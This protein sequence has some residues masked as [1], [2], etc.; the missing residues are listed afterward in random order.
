MKY[1]MVNFDYIKLKRF[2]S[3]KPNAT[4]IRREA[5]KWEGI[6]KT[7]VCDKG[8]ISKIYRE[9]SQIYKNT[10]YS[11]VDK[12]SKDLKRQFSEEEIKAIYSHMKKC[13][14][15]LLI[16]EMQIKTVRYHITPIRLANMIKQED[17]KVGEDVGELE[18]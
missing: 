15:S 1:K 5:E 16:R 2:C 14:K 13:S 3:N 17:D 4:N 8:L 18:H 12:W 6:F 9:L 7:N 10:S 11:P